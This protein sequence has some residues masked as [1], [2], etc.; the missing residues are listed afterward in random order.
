MGSAL[1]S[2]FGG[3]CGS[4]KGRGEAPHTDLQC[5]VS[6]EAGLESGERAGEGGEG[7]VVAAEASRRAADRDSEGA[8]VRNQD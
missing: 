6:F 1:I 2:D 3:G 4:P 8:E 5:E 7:G